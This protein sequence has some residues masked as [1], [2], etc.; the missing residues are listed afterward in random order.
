MY[1]GDITI[2][3]GVRKTTSGLNLEMFDLKEA[4]NKSNPAS[5]KNYLEDKGFDSKNMVVKPLNLKKT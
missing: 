3:S 1:I 4:Y 2:R 5:A